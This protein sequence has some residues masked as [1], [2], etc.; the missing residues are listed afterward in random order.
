MIALN[1]HVFQW[2]EKESD[3]KNSWGRSSRRAFNKHCQDFYF[4]KS[5]TPPIPSTLS[6]AKR[7]YLSSLL[8]FS[9]SA[10][11]NIQLREKPFEINHHKNNEGKAIYSS[12]D[13]PHQD[14]KW[15]VQY[16]KMRRR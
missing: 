16:G 15:R 4:A 6:H 13:S 5:S 11:D 8:S 7:H 14:D 3:K 2:A 12:D 10:H 9:K 1:P